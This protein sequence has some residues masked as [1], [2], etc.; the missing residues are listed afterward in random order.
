MASNLLKISA[1]HR[2]WV[3]YSSAKL[4][5]FGDKMSAVVSLII[6]HPILLEINFI[7]G[8]LEAFFEDLF[9]VYILML[10]KKN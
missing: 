4:W 7:L 1:I 6:C 2:P 9:C 10:L 3:D 5:Y 8:R